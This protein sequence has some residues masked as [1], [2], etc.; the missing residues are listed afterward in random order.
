ML[1]GGVLTDLSKLTGAE[2]ANEAYAINNKG[3]VCVGT[4]FENGGLIIDIVHSTVQN[5]SFAGM[6]N[7]Q[8]YTI[9]ENGD[10]AGTCIVNGNQHGFWF[11][12]QTCADLGPVEYPPIK[13]NNT[14]TL[15]GVWGVT[16]T[17]DPTMSMPKGNNLDL[18]ATAEIMSINDSGA[19]VGWMAGGTGDVAILF[20]GKNVTDLNSQISEAGWNL[21]QAYAINSTG[22]IAG[23]GYL[24]GANMGFLLDPI[25]PGKNPWPW[26]IATARWAEL[27]AVSI[28]WRAASM[29]ACGGKDFRDGRVPLRELREARSQRGQRPEPKTYGPFPG[30]FGPIRISPQESLRGSYPRRL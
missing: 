30:G 4:E 12:G 16:W 19:M 7:P 15:L 8:P 9:N 20:D 1:K 24:N 14:G 26:W 3:L 10:F 22:Q 11:R 6:N 25:V 2:Q 23:A 17:W 29:G 28:G 5:L 13:L 27:L 21:T 18:P